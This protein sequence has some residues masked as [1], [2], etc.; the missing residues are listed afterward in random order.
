MRNKIISHESLQSSAY[1]RV[2]NVNLMNMW[3]CSKEM[4]RNFSVEKGS[5]QESL[6]PAAAKANFSVYEYNV[7]SSQLDAAQIDNI[8]LSMT[9]SNIIFHARCEVASGKSGEELNAP[10]AKISGTFPIFHFV[11]IE[12]RFGVVIIVVLSIHVFGLR[13]CPFDIDIGKLT[14][15]SHFPYYIVEIAAYEFVNIHSTQH[16]ARSTRT[17]DIAQNENDDSDKG[18]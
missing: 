13:K 3:L 14:K 11:S 5:I 2:P 1:E 18:R 15:E 6:P 7:N 16:A 10:F 12:Q 4:H 17:N 9:I 8:I